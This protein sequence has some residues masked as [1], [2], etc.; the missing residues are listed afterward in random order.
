[1]N[2]KHIGLVL[3]ILLS[4]TT[5]TL[6]LNLAPISQNTA[7]HNFSDSNE[8]F[9]IP[10]LLNVISN[11]PFLVIGFLG[12]YKLIYDNTLVI[13]NENKAAYFALFAGTTLVFFGS[14]FY[15]LQP[16]NTTLA[17]D[18]LPMTIAFMSLFSI[19]I[20]EY[21]SIKVGK[22]LLLPFLF[23]GLYSVYYWHSTELSGLGD[24]RAYAL[25]Q[26][27]PMLAIPIILTTYK[28][29]HNDTAAYWYVLIMYIVAKVLEYF[30]QGIHHVI[31]FISGHSL[32]HIAAAIGVY[33]L[34]RSYQNRVFN[35]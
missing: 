14:S 15:H 18:R 27:F 1:M 28:A 11:L 32:K 20:S 6:A 24:L 16:N 30:D 19:V 10:N 2:K 34:I 8:Y 4:L 21:I 13:I 9:N 25:V 31:I 29:D 3:I 22:L 33:I 5:I 26:F 17:W 12:L 35:S 23:L 7:Y